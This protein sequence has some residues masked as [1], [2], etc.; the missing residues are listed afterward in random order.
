MINKEKRNEYQ[1]KLYKENLER[2]RAYNRKSYWKNKENRDKSAREYQRKAKIDVMSHYSNGEIKCACC[3]VKE[4]VFLTIDHIKGDGN[5]L[6]KEKKH[7]TGGMFYIWLRTNKYPEGL[8]VL[9]HNCNQ[10]KR[11]LSHCPHKDL[12]STQPSQE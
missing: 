12:L 10:A 11:Q 4:I 2:G 9:C 3:G 8:Q 6:R 7:K 1:R 5:K